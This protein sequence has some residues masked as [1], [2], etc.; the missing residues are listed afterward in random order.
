MK[1]VI[2]LKLVEISQ[3]VADTIINKMSD[4]NISDYEFH[5]LYNF[6]MSLILYV[7][8][9]LGVQLD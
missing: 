6:G 2:K 3:M 9:Y 5:L 1:K 7:D 4:T 8:F